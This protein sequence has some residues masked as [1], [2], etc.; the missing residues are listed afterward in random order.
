MSALQPRFKLHH[1]STHHFAEY[2]NNIGEPQPFISELM[3]KFYTELLAPNFPIKEE[4]QPLDEFLFLLSE[5]ALHS[6]FCGRH[7]Y[8]IMEEI[9]RCY[10]VEIYIEYVIQLPVEK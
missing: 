9:V 10:S 4:L 2:F 3:N 5:E 1:F 8:L 6:T 7:H